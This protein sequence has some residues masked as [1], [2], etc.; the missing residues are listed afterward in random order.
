MNLAF[1]TDLLPKT[2]ELNDAAKAAG[3]THAGVL[4]K[5]LPT[6][7]SA[8]LSMLVRTKLLTQQ[9]AEQFLRSHA[10]TLHAFSTAETLGEA[11][12]ADN[13]LTPYQFDRV[14]AG[15]SYGL[16]LG[17][18][19]V[20]RRIGAGAMGVVFL[21]EHMMM[22]RQVAIKVL[23]V[24]ALCPQQVIERFNVE[25]R[26][27]AQLQHPN[28]VTAFDCGEVQPEAGFP[29]LLYLVMEYVDGCD[30]EQFVK[31]QGPAPLSR[32]CDWIRQAACG[33]QEAHNR[34]LVHRDIK[35]SNVLLTK[36]DQVKLV[37]FGLVRQFSYS[38]TDPKATLGTLEF[39]PPEQS[40]DPSSV[41]TQADI[42]A[43]GATLFFILTGKPLFPP[44]PTLMA[45]M[46][47]LRETP[48]PRLRTFRP[49]APPELENL[50]ARLLDRD[51][52][53][54]PP[55]AV[56]VAKALESFCG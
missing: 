55:M 54:R 9:S 44:A 29:H 27:L 49:D 41:G 56:T 48:V 18:Y 14:M 45:A 36:Q 38:M 31:K 28:I 52:L 24:D 4:E 1:D 47:Q 51:P 32:A 8:F 33:L 53:R 22:R 17:N 21:G 10:Q 37:D 16:V 7:A 46:K 15:T 20:L 3:P 13:L 6:A 2:V 26:V 42:Y 40:V 12:V 11:L 39:M 35:P 30:L 19:R 34:E 23:P 5:E 43:L 25:M 50:V